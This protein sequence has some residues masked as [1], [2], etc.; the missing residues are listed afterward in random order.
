MCCG[1][2]D[3]TDLTDKTGVCYPLAERED[4]RC[5]CAVSTHPCLRRMT[6][7]DFRCDVCRGAFFSAPAPREDCMEVM[8]VRQD[9]TWLAGT[10]LYIERGRRYE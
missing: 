4:F 7:E 1:T 9:K 3:R 6:G 10:T 5:Q 8:E 2:H